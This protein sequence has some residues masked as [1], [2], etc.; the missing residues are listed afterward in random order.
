MPKASLFRGFSRF[1]L[2]YRIQIVAIVLLQVAVVAASLAIP[3]VLGAVIQGLEEQRA[4]LSFLM[5]NLVTIILVYV[6]WNSFRGTRS[7]LRVCQQ[8]HRE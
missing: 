3:Y 8:V 5:T 7:A 1:L 4:S 6:V 2:P